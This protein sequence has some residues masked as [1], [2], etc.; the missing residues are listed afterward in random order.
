MLGRRPASDWRRSPSVCRCKH[1]W[2]K[3]R[4]TLRSV[5]VS[6]PSPGGMEFE[7]DCTYLASNDELGPRGGLSLEMRSVRGPFAGSHG[8]IVNASSK[9]PKKRMD[10]TLTK[11]ANIAVLGP[12]VPAIGAKRRGGSEQQHWALGRES[13]RSPTTH[14]FS[15]RVHSVSVQQTLDVS[16]V[17]PA[18]DP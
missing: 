8:E 16:H 6:G 1:G 7:F 3:A 2:L 17:A 4:E 10:L 18:T 15:A 12:G 9:A 14:H 13:A 5:G 11:M